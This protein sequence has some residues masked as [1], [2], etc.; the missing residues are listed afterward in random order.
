MNGNRVRVVVIEAE[1]SDAILGQVLASALAA[2]FDGAAEQPA[3]ALPSPP[4]EQDRRAL[5]PAPAKR[6]GGPAARRKAA[7]RQAPPKQEAAVDAGTREKILA[8][9]EKKPMNS[10][11]VV[12]ATGL[13]KSNVYSMLHIL[14]KEGVVESREEENSI[15]PVQHLVKK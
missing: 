10:G 4:V 6:E 1:G 3:P 9:L 14:R 8:A 12:R 5:S 15:Y 13:S 2:R 7:A 11:D